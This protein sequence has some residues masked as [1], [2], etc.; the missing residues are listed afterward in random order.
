MTWYPWVKHLSTI[1]SYVRIPLSQAETF[2]QV[3]YL[4]L[5][6]G[7][8]LC[9]IVSCG[10]CLQQ[11]K[12]FNV[13]IKKEC[14]LVNDWLTSSIHLSWKHLVFKINPHLLLNLLLSGKTIKVREFM[15]MI[16]QLTYVLSNSD[17][18][19]SMTQKHNIFKKNYL[20]SECQYGN[21]HTKINFF[22]M[23]A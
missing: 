19:Q 20:H 18:Q 12:I 2:R 14:F 11:F 8:I 17:A 4:Q 7:N 5:C 15:Q 9:C 6:S 22:E 13:K 1:L 23:N 16:L 21:M 3:C 10:K